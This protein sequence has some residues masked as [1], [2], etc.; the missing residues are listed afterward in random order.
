MLLIIPLNQTTVRIG[1]TI[2]TSL[3]NCHAAEK[4]PWKK[5]KKALVIPQPGQ[6]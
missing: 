6:L 2:I 1:K 4:S 5:A 3:L